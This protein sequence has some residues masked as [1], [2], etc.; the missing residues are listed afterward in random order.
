MKSLGFVL[1]IAKTRVKLA[2]IMVTIPYPVGVVLRTT[3][4]NIVFVTAL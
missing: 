1:E 3:C 4:K 2:E